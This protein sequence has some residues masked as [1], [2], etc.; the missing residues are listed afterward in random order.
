MGLFNKKQNDALR[1]PL[2]YLSG[3]PLLVEQ[4]QCIISLAEEKII[5]QT[6]DNTQKFELDFSQIINIQQNTNQQI[7]EKKKSV[8]KRGIVGDVLMGST[9]A[10]IGG[11]SGLGTK[12]QSQIVHDL[13][14]VYTT[15]NTNETKT[16]TFRSLN[17]NICKKIVDNVNSNLTKEERNIK[18]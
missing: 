1:C 16:L 7:T 14:I 5:I 3:L 15:S 4:T 8:I 13:I 17:P 2:V 9:G 18:L 12:E 11:L 6:M 10:I